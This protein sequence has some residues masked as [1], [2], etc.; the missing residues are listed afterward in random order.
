MSRWKVKI[1]KSFEH[2]EYLLSVTSL[3]H[4]AKLLMQDFSPLKEPRI[5]FSTYRDMLAIVMYRV[6]SLSLLSLEDAGSR[7]L[8]TK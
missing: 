3:L 2:T 4:E 8:G 1:F 5:C 6:L 7:G